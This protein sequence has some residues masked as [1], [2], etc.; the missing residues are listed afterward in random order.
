M[1]LSALTLNF[2]HDAGPYPRRGENISSIEVE[3]QVNQHPAVLESA[4]FGVSDEHTEQEVMAV[5]TPIPGE[6]I[7]PAELTAFVNK[8]L[9]HFMVPRY[10]KI[11]GEIEKT[12]TGKIQKRGLREKG[13]TPATW[14]RVAA[15]VQLER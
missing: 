11:V 9:P 14:D 8:R 10:I 6:E 12:P 4:V 2:W 13:V 1:T 3:D 7:D 5:V 15:G